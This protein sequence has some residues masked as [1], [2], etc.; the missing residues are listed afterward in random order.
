M[1]FLLACL[2]I[3]ALAAAGW[4]FWNHM[5]S[6]SPHLNFIVLTINGEPRKILSGESILLHP[7]DKVKISEISTSIP[8]N[9]NIRLVAEN[10]DV[11]ALRFE[12]MPVAQLL[13][14]HEIFNHYT[15]RVQVKHYNEN[16]GFMIWN[17][18]PFAEDWLDK[19][20][21]I[22]DDKLRLELLERGVALLPDQ[23]KLKRRLLDEYKKQKKWEKAARLLE[24]MEGKGKEPNVL[25]ELLD[26]YGKTGNKE[27]VIQVLKDLVKIEPENVQAGF[28][29][30]AA[31]EKNGAFDQAI[32]EYIALIAKTNEQDRLVIYKNL[33][34]LY[35]K[36]EKWEEAIACY[37]KA[38]ELD[39]K[40]PN[41]YYNL[42]Y[43][44]EKINDKEHADFYLENAITIKSDDL[45]GKLKLA[46]NL[47]ENGEDE[48]VRVYLSQILKKDVN[49]LEA[50]TLMARLLEKTG[51]KSALKSVYQRMLSL[52]EDNQTILYNLG[53]LEYETGDLK[54]SLFYLNKY[55]AL[56]PGD[57]TAHGILFDIYKQQKNTD[58]ALKEAHIIQ[59]IDPG[60][61]DAYQYIFDHLKQQSDFENAIPLFEQGLKSTPDSTDLIK[62]LITAYLKTDRERLAIEEMEK[63]LVKAPGDISPL[64][65]DMFDQLNKKG[66]YA[67]II[68][69]ME[70][71]THV[72]PKK[73]ELKEYLIVAYLKTSNEKAAILE[74]EKVLSLKPDDVTLLLQLAKLSEKNNDIKRAV[75][76]YKRVL[77][78]AP[79]NEEASDAY[80]R[81]RLEGV[82]SQ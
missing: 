75:S 43:L 59:A 56:Q 51:D 32:Q 70:K 73:V 2:F 41:I 57:A 40:D 35:T 7:N 33:G 1:G 26:V 42:S 54:K 20:N 31:F 65:Q 16:M 66:L 78:I 76:A 38:A 8:L 13:P 74:M 4:W 61:M 60:E 36:T 5:T 68:H 77:D 58:M 21:R 19:A 47:F 30:A 12:E 63:L 55:I 3:L 79:N 15:F 45:A 64:L 27:R 72:Y 48:K 11:N 46:R 23:E 18:R 71:A 37:L 82:G 81:L 53:V 25:K 62:Y 9:L 10:F 34:Y 28:Q 17:I 69:I 39:Q 29:L 22:I 44:Y 49:N 67:D 6:P 50:L 24:K 80:L 52:Q 14:E